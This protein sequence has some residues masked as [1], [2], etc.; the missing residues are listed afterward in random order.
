M[1]DFIKSIMSVDL[2]NWLFMA[3]KML[4]YALKTT[5]IYYNINRNHKKFIRKFDAKIDKGDFHCDFHLS[6]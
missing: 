5:S 1:I 4:C 3:L 6:W 2:L